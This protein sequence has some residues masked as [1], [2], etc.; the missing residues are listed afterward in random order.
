MQESAKHVTHQFPNELSKSG[1]LIDAIQC[2]GAR[3]QPTMD[4]IKSDQYTNGMLNNF[5]YVSTNLLPYDPVQKNKIYHAGTKHVSAEIPDTTGD[6]LHMTLHT[7]VLPVYLNMRKYYRRW[8]MIA[9][10]IERTVAR[11]WY[12]VAM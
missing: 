11:V 4:S 7:R 6:W 5:E 1:Y 9:R 3:F 10:V 12:W 2:C 8:G